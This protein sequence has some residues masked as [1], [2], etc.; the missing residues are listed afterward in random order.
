M[1]NAYKQLSA[2]TC[3][4]CIQCSLERSESVRR[5][6]YTGLVQLDALVLDEARERVLELELRVEPEAA[7]D[8]ARARGEP[9]GDERDRLVVDA[10]VEPRHLSC[11][12]RPWGGE[13]SRKAQ[14]S[15]REILV[16]IKIILRIRCKLCNNAALSLCV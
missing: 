5:A 15:D 12:V 10:V 7:V 2:V 11:T 14:L 6:F 9:L 8:P 13:E 3:I 4:G 16:V 1:S